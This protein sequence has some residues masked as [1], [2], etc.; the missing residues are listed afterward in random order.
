ILPEVNQNPPSSGGTESADSLR[1]SECETEDGGFWLT[2]E[3]VDYVTSNDDKHIMRLLE[4]I[5]ILEVN[6][7]V[8]NDIDD[9]NFDE[10]DLKDV[11]DILPNVKYLFFT[12]DITNSKRFKR[13][14]KFWLMQ[15]TLLRD[16][17]ESQFH[18]DYDEKH[19]SIWF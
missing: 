14:P 17:Q 2:S 12:F 11:S 7:I 10:F 3:F 6:L 15:Y 13:D 18:V 5:Q 19:L 8:L 4:R 1:V 16:K 9:C